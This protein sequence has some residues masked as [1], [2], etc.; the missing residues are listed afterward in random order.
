MFWSGHSHRPS[1]S[2]VNQYNI[3][4]NAAIHLFGVGTNINKLGVYV[5]VVVSKS[6]LNKHF[7]RSLKCFEI[8]NRRQGPKTAG[9]YFEL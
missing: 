2:D 7:H 9:G 6:S 8:K 5:R 4:K 1:N 3:C